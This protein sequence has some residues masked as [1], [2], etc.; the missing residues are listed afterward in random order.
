[1]TDATMIA[2]NQI[3][4]LPFS[5]KEVTFSGDAIAETFEL[6][7]SAHNEMIASFFQT[8]PMQD[9]STG[10]MC[11]RGD[12]SGICKHGRF[13][14]V[15]GGVE[16]CEFEISDLVYDQIFQESV[17]MLHLQRCGCELKYEEAGDFAHKICHHEPAQIYGTK[18]RIDVSGGWHDAGDYGRYIVPAAKAVADLMLACELYPEKTEFAVSIPGCPK[19]EPAL[20]YE[21]RYEIDWMLKMQRQDGGVYHKVTCAEFPDIRTMPEDETDKLIV[22]PVSNAAT[23]TFAASMVCA[24]RV[25]SKLDPVYADKLLAAAKSA[26]A[27]ITEH[28]DAEG[29][30]NPSGIVTGEYGD[31]NW[32]DEYFWALAEMCRTTEERQY[33]MLLEELG[34]G[35]E[36]L[37]PQLGWDENGLYGAYAYIKSTNRRK[38]IEG[39]CM[40]ALVKAADEYVSYSRDNGYG[41]AIADGNYPWGSNMVVANRGMLCAL[42]SRI[43]EISEAKREQYRVVLER[44]LAYLLGRNGMG[45]CYVTGFGARSPQNPHHRPSAVV[46]KPMRGMLVGG[47]DDGMH[48]P[49][50]AEIFHNTPS[51]LCYT[52]TLESYSTNEVTIYWNTPLIFLIAAITAGNKTV[53]NG[54]L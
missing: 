18:D 44:Q 16:S 48:D 4:Y 39:A 21:V 37:T 41:C 43:P 33:H 20:L 54:V 38:S 1:M 29:F 7:D 13:K 23:A 5:K 25:F 53:R 35:K 47:P 32:K 49:V 19:Y 11:S 50:A 51:Q 10:R 27:Y 3:G 42:L 36:I 14:I 45:Y 40:R 46:G 15:A 8:K 24:Y 17:Y 28:K 26:I 30:T 22:S 9:R 12:F 34:T 52:D 2:I 6:Y 31:A